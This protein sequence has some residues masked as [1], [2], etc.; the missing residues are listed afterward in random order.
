MTIK[1]TTISKPRMGV[2]NV[3]GNS[4]AFC[5]S[6][7]IDITDQLMYPEDAELTDVQTNICTTCINE[8]EM[9]LAPSLSDGARR[10]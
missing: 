2:C 3:C 9:E 4:R 6:V 5:M 1:T 10:R 7:S 8:R